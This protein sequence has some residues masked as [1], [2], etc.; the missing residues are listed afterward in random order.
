[1][2]DVRGHGHGTEEINQTHEILENGSPNHD[3]DFTPMVN[4]T[5]GNA[6]LAPLNATK[7]WEKARVLREVYKLRGEERR[8]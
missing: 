7:R 3:G 6:T 2:H 5:V 4:T 1:V 8:D